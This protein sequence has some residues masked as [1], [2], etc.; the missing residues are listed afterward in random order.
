MFE[1]GLLLK[2]TPEDGSTVTLRDVNRNM[3][4]VWN[5]NYYKMKKYKDADGYTIV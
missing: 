3:I 5:W 1:L 4:V 2:G